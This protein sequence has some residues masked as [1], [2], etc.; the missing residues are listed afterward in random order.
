MAKLNDFQLFENVLIYINR[1]ANYTENLTEDKLNNDLKTTDAVMYC[2][3]QIGKNI[4]KI[5]NGFQQKHREI[6]GIDWA[7]LALLQKDDYFSNEDLW[8]IINDESGGILNFYT[9]MET[10][11]LKERQKPENKTIARIPARY[12]KK[13]E[14]EKLPLKKGTKVNSLSDNLNVS[15]KGFNPINHIASHS[16]IWTV[17]KK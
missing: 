3:Q 15:K 12:F 6:S 7:M 10:I 11:Y 9:N 2:I 5:S 17:K 1:I 4:A 14:N 13:D 8:D 16:S